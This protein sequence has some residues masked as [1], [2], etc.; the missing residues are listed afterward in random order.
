MI[1]GESGLGKATLINSLFNTT[2]FPP[3]EEKEN[4]NDVPTTVEMQTISTE[5]DEKDVRL[6]LTV[7]NALGF[8]DFLNNEDAWK[9]ILNNVRS[10]YAAYLEQDSRINR[11][12]LVDSRVHACIYLIS[13]TGHSLRSL[14]LEFLKRLSGHV[15]LIPVIAKAD[16][17][18][19]EE[20][21]SFKARILDDIAVH[22]IKIYHPVVY[23]SDG[24]HLIQEN[25]EI[26]SSVPFAVIGSNKMCDVNGK[27]VMGRQ[28]P[29]GSIDIEDEDYSDF[30]KLRK[31]LIL[32]H[33]EDL[34]DYTNEVLYENFRVERINS[35]KQQTGS[36]DRICLNSISRL[37]EEKVAYKQKI[38]KMEAEMK[39]L[40]NQKVQEKEKK[41][42]E[43]ENDLYVRHREVKEKLEKQL[44]EFEEL[45]RKAEASRS[46]QS[47]KPKKKQ[48]LFK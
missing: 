3:K 43:S 19:E 7:I 40:F 34:K 6:R 22:K 9:P 24:E 16:S 4:T 8:G 48:G 41:L 47:E 37:Q 35:L 42:H 28:Y 27:N 44:A 12:N 11:K 18:T 36:S 2:V 1:V 17:F 5:I 32:T 45:K 26:T 33:M 23:D 15:N 25:K 10:R 46:G 29:W 21:R 31:M 14:D 13:P 38:T 20:L 30:L 39:A